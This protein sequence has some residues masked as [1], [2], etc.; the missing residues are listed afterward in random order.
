MVAY[1]INHAAWHEGAATH[2]FVSR[3]TGPVV[4]G[5][6]DVLERPR[7]SMVIKTMSIEGR[8]IETQV[9]VHTNDRNWT[10]LDYEWTDDGRDARP[11]ARSKTKTL[12]DGSTWTFPGPDGCPQCHNTRVGTLRALTLSQ[13]DRDS[14]GKPQLDRLEER[15]VVAWRDEDRKLP[16][17]MPSI[18]DASASL[19]DRARAYLHVN[20]SACHQPG[21]FSGQADMDLRTGRPLRAMR[22]CDIAPNAEFAGHEAALLVAPGAP[23][24]SLISIRMHIEGSGAMPPLRRRADSKG[25]K[26]I[27]DW[28]RSLE[29][30]GPL[31]AS[32]G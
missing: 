24:R 19:E 25:T 7:G 4:Y 22:I 18:A 31:T 28:I 10:G 6:Q 21:G 17:P 30:C 14:D 8:P 23:D 27:D 20:C 3:G 29:S 16:P 15:R 5:N 12:P 32:A 1:E 26:L 2:R 9:L 13:L 11:L